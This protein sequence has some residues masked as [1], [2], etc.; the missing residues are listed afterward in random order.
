MQEHEF[1]ALLQL[2]GMAKLG[3]MKLTL[4]QSPPAG[5]TSYGVTDDDRR[6]ILECMR[7]CR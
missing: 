2:A 7:P 1:V 5:Y 3:F 6:C 4:C